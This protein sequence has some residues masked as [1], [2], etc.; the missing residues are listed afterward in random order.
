MEKIKQITV[1]CTDAENDLIQRIQQK[2]GKEFENSR[3]LLNFLLLEA[4]KEK[5]RIE[6]PVEI[7][8]EKEVE[9]QLP[10][11]SI[12]LLCDKEEKR[13]LNDTSEICEMLGYSTGHKDLFIKLIQVC[14]GRGELIIDNEDLLKL[15]EKREL[16][17]Q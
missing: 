5:E 14:H 4:L 17:K 3:D 10:E 9:K 16:E 7:E 1:K 15:E 2:T 6:V 13:I 8:V 12:L 11:N